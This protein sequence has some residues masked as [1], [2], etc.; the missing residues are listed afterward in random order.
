MV[1]L[2]SAPRLE[3]SR[4]FE[5]DGTS[6]ETLLGVL[7]FDPS[8]A[9]GF[10]VAESEGG[11]VGNP[12]ELV[13]SFLPPFER[14][15]VVA[16]DY[17]ISNGFPTRRAVFSLADGA[18]MLLHAA[19]GRRRVYAAYVVVRADAF[20]TRQP[21]VARY[22]DSVVID[23]ADSPGASGDGRFDP[24][25]AQ[26]RYIYPLVDDFACILP[27]RPV[28]REESTR[29]GAQDFPTS[30]YTSSSADG[31]YG[32]EVRVVTTRAR[33][34]ERLFDEVRD[35]T[36]RAGYAVESEAPAHHQGFAGREIVLGSQASSVRLRM[37]ATESRLYVLRAAWP[38]AQSRSAADLFFDSLRIL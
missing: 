3:R 20:R 5:P 28:R 38:R 18:L 22:L 35:L 26:W 27:G 7:Q 36:V 24:A 1:Q 12:V 15:E 6:V 32:Y 13:D 9:L 16:D 8:L 11:L 21:I 34:P 25:N 37:I 14:T 33:P 17:T 2:P 19:V 10:A 31:S 30:V 29:S 23:R 4:Q